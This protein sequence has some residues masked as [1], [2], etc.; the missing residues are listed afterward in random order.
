MSTRWSHG[1]QILFRAVWKG[2]VAPLPMTVVRDTADLLALYT[3]PG[4]AGMLP[5]VLQ[6][7]FGQRFQ[8]RAAGGWAMREVRWD[9]THV[10]RLISPGVDHSVWLMWNDQTWELVCWYVNLEEPASRTPYGLECMDQ[11]LDIVISPDLESWRWKDED[12]LADAQEAGLISKRRTRELR[13]EGLRVISNM[14]A[15]RPPFD[16]PW[17][18]WRPDPTWPILDLPEEW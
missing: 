1:D 16:H 5:A 12:H 8:A 9:R 11:E 6:D 4:T 15:R 14:E 10:L 2:E 3:A 13:A 17:P 7:D 18:E